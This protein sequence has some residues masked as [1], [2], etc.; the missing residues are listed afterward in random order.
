MAD[1]ETLEEIAERLRRSPFL[2]QPMGYFPPASTTDTALSH[3]HQ[4]KLY[5]I[6][7]K[8]VDLTIR[9]ELN[10]FEQSD[11][12]EPIEGLDALFAGYANDGQF[13]FEDQ[14]VTYVQK[15]DGSRWWP[16]RFALQPTFR[17][18]DLVSIEAADRRMTHILDA[19]DV[20][21][22]ILLLTW[23]KLRRALTN[24]ELVTYEGLEKFYA[25]L[26]QVT[27]NAAG[28][29]ELWVATLPDRESARADKQ[30]FLPIHHKNRTGMVVQLTAP[31]LANLLF[32]L[33]QAG[34][35]RDGI[36]FARSYFIRRKPERASTLR[37]RIELLEQEL[38]EAREE[39]AEL[40]GQ[41][42]PSPSDGE[43]E[44]IEE[45]TGGEDD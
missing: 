16:E 23:S 12:N 15:K 9:L 33:E 31:F 32:L 28:E 25:N 2:S 38:E 11:A 42:Q 29:R 18:T 17:P 13:D 24:G 19:R 39:L 5:P 21:P 34:A 8:R 4:V 7:R 26:Y 3:L 1:E 37:H 40:E 6:P 44:D 36:D 20:H 30:G 10:R 35:A 27:K 43:D 45:P 41:D 22:R 14:H